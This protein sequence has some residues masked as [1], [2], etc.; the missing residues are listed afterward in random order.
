MRL[1]Y[2]G[3]EFGLL[4]TCENI[5]G[6]CTITKIKGISSSNVNSFFLFLFLLVS[7]TEEGRKLDAAVGCAL[8]DSSASV[9]VSRNWTGLVK[10]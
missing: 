5:W 2:C 1:A 10:F 8:A 4:N 3:R 6:L 9:T 7:L